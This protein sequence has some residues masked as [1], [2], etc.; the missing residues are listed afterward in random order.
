[1]QIG[2]HDATEI[3]SSNRKTNP[4]TDS[5]LETSTCTCE[6]VETLVPPAAFSFSSAN[7]AGASS[8]TLA[9]QGGVCS[10]ESGEAEMRS[11][12]DTGR[13]RGR[14]DGDEEKKKSFYDRRQVP[15]SAVNKQDVTAKSD[16]GS[17]EECSKLEFTKD[18]VFALLSERAKAGKFDTKGKIER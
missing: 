14:G 3:F 4:G 10:E 5:G 18:E 2:R 9:N 13:W 15:S 16:V 11:S 17:V 7:P 1:M 12:A 8:R 6:A